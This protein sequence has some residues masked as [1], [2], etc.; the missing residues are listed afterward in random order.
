M[1]LFRQQQLRSALH[2]SSFSNI[3]DAAA[4]AAAA[5]ASAAAAA[6]ESPPPSMAQAAAA[7][8]A[9]AG[10]AGVI[11][12]MIALPGGALL[13][14]ALLDFRVHPQV[15]VNDWAFDLCA[16]GI[17]TYSATWQWCD[18]ICA[19]LFCWLALHVTHTNTRTAPVVLPLPVEH[20]MLSGQHSQCIFAS[21]CLCGSLC[22]YSILTVPRGWPATASCHIYYPLPS[23]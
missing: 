5:N 18:T 21:F 19:I 15:R 9:V 17:M 12:G 22:C 8:A 1:S 14:P 10:A 16:L 20:N 3:G 6:T 4:V 13:A 23:L 2:Q 7:A 11:S